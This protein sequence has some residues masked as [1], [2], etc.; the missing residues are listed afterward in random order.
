MLQTL[1]VFLFT[2]LYQN[3]AYLGATPLLKQ[4]KQYFDHC[5]KEIRYENFKFDHF[6]R[7]KATEK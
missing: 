3:A 2:S 7:K 5:K 4:L 6:T 1:P